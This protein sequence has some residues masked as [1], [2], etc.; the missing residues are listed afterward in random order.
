MNP[1]SLQAFITLANQ[2]HYGKAAEL[3]HMTTSTLSRMITRL[4]EEVGVVLFLRTKREVSVTEAGHAFYRFAT[5]TLEQ[6]EAFK[7]SV[8]KGEP[9][10]VIRLYSTVT[11][12]YQIL[13]PMLRALQARYPEISTYLETGIAKNGFTH[14][15]EGK[16][17]FAVGI[18]TDK[19]SSAF[20]CHKLLET[21][22]IFIVPTGDTRDLTSIPMILPE[23][24]VMTTM[25]RDYLRTHHIEPIVHSYVEGHEA[26]LSMV[27]AGLG[28]A[29]LPKIVV[30]NNPL[31]QAVQ[32]TAL[33][34]P[35]P[36]L[37][38]G[39]FTKNTPTMS[40]VKRAF[41]EFVQQQGEIT[42]S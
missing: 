20:L 34:D 15:E 9:R 28:G 14:L 29:I 30:E 31:R 38:V 39:I 26:I 36:V 12:A 33:R 5:E 6:F 7:Q 2:L 42:A 16:A 8:H 13:P 17:D 24:G 37:E 19:Q 10:G 40:P 22:L 1:K 23:S 41:W 21:P 18:I 25:I 3:C 4:E 32:I 11:A 27:A 35:L